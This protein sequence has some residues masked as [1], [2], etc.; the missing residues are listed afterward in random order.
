M[1]GAEDINSGDV[2]KLNKNSLWGKNKLRIPANFRI[3][4]IFLGLWHRLMRVP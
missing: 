4:E 3:I 2:A 1:S